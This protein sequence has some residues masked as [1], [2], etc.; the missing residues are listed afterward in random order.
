MIEKIDRGEVELQYEEGTG[1]LQSLLKELDIPVSSQ[2]LVFSKTS[3]QVRYISPRN[4]RAIYFN[5]DVYVGWVRGSPLME[6]STSDPKL[7]A[8]FYTVK[9]SPRDAY[10]K[11]AN[12]ECLACHTTTLTQG[13]PGHTVRS[14]NPKIDGS[15][16]AQKPSFVT[17]HTSPFSERWGGW[18]VTGRSGDMR[19]MGNSFLRQD[20]LD[21]KN[22]GNRLNLRDEF[23]TSDW[24]SPYSDIVALMVLEHQTQMHNTFTRANFAVRRAIYEH[25]T[26]FPRSDPDSDRTRREE[27]EQELQAVIAQA[28]REVVDF[29]LFVNEAPLESEVKGSLVFTSEF[30]E[31]GP[32]SNSGRSLREFDLKERLFKY[33]CSYLIYSPAFDSL[34]DSLREQIGLRLWAVLKNPDDS[35][36][37]EHLD[38]KTRE[39]IVEILR[40]TKSGLPA[41]WKS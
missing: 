16:D 26:A 41:C 3:M 5:D 35:E 21:T 11:R 25:N 39:S 14:V 32:L 19:H 28:A 12:Y 15:M 38:A 7:G 29:L 1:Y 33:P 24:L 18:Y 9:M 20:Q 36:R 2:A 6:I 31:R 22:N 34:E 17:D 4:P 13:V 30:S 37:Y 27:S 8:A 23:A 10:I 40:D